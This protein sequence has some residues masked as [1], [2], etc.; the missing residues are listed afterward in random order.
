MTFKNCTDA[1]NQGVS[2]IPRTSPSY[3]ARLDRDKD[4]VGCERKDAPAG[5][6]PR[7]EQTA[8]PI[9][10]KSH[11][12]APTRTK[13]TGTVTVIE[14]GAGN[15]TALPKTGPGEITAVGGGIIL[16]GAVALVALRRKRT[17]FSA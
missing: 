5:F 2:D 14:N 10:S 17:R 16:L 15:G 11:T 4:G 6:T 12:P 9:P 1:Y 3:A 7:V 8:K 13:E